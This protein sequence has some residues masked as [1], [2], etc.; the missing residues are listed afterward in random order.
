MTIEKT[1]AIEIPDEVIEEYANNKK[2][3][4]DDMAFELICKYGNTFFF[5]MI[6]LTT[7]QKRA[8]FEGIIAKT[9]K[10]KRKE[11]QKRG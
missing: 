9:L 2:G 7:G 11:N 8:L 1:I 4:Y 5:D 6:N 3:T 10:E